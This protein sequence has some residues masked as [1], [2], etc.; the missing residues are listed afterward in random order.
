M[1]STIYFVDDRFG[2]SFLKVPVAYWS[3]K[4][5]LFS[6]KMKVLNV[7]RIIQLH[8]QPKKKNGM[9]RELEPASLF[10]KF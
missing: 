10:F 9:V 6:F 5:V 8:F 3:R 4:A 2:V 7:F 1:E